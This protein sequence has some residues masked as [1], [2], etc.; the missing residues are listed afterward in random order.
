MQQEQVDLHS[1][2][3]AKAGIQSPCQTYRGG[4]DRLPELSPLRTG[5]ADLPH[6]ALRSMVILLRTGAKHDGHR[7]G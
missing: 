4:K 2:I 7:K 5:R 1:V 6:P 3:P